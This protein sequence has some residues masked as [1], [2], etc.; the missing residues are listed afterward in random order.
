MRT[1]AWV[2]AVILLAGLVVH[3]G[4]QGWW[5]EPVL[6]RL[7]QYPLM[8]GATVLTAF[9]DRARAA[10]WAFTCGPAQDFEH[11]R[12]ARVIELHA[13]F[14]F[15]FKPVEEDRVAF[16]F[17]MRNFNSDGKSGA[18]IGGAEDRSHTAACGYSVYPIFV[19]LVAGVK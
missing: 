9:N 15:A 17:R 14:F 18:Q 19:E 13:D 11:L 3:G 16:H 7:G 2:G 5:I 12:D 10:G 1:V 4:L 8:L 6:S